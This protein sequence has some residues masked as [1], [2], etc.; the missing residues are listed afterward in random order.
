MMLDLL[1]GQVYWAD[2]DPVRGHEQA[3]RR[4]VLILSSGQSN[5]RSELAI[6]LPITGSPQRTE[7]TYSPQLESVEMPMESWILLRQIRTIS[8]ERILNYA[9]RVSNAELKRVVL[10]VLAHMLPPANDIVIGDYPGLA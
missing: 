4:P 10:A 7:S 8:E 2:L 9:G 6:V 5:S 1:R 3:G